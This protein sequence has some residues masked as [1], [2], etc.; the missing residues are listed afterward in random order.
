MYL[1]IPPNAIL[2]NANNYKRATRKRNQLNDLAYKSATAYVEHAFA[3]PMFASYYIIILGENV[4]LA[5]LQ[6]SELFT[7]PN[8]P[9]P[10]GG[11][12]SEDALTVYIGIAMSE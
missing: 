9:L 7:Y 3:R 4:N 5:M 12:I 2:R 10:K 8:T 11:R 1:N 6:L